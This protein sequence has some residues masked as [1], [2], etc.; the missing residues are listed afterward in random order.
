MIAID[1]QY[2]DVDAVHGAIVNQ[3]IGNAPE[4]AAE[5]QSL[6]HSRSPTFQMLDVHR[7]GERF[8]I[9]PRVSEFGQFSHRAI[10]ELLLAPALTR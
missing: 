4:Q 7:Y 3:V 5:L 1:A 2:R 9:D 8:V 6:W 10:R